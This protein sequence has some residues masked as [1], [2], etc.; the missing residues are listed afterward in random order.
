M[1]LALLTAE[2]EASYW[3]LVKQDYCD[4]YFFIY[5]LLLQKEKTKVSLALDQ[6]RIAGLMLVYDESMVQLRGKPD[7]V[8]F[9]LD[10]LSLKKVEVQAPISCEAEVLS[11]FPT[12]TEKGNLVL[13]R[14]EKG[15]VNYDV[16]L[17]PER[18]HAADA[19][20]VALLMNECYPQL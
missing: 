14:V 4:Y 12:Y 6:D 5:D 17:K 15:S 3:K 18:L 11:K 8:G 20:E 19:E 7:A 2:L 13:M 16:T 9:L 10:S 1:R